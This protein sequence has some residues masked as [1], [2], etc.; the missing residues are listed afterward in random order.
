VTKV[1]EEKP[2]TKTT[3][4]ATPV[5]NKEK[6]EEDGAPVTTA[7]KSE[8]V[9]TSISTYNGATT[10]RYNWSQGINE[11]TVQIKIPPGTRAK[12]VRN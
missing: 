10:E 4:Q 8:H 5:E 2:V 1:Q 12:N 7:P 3:T 11:V 6:I 9:D